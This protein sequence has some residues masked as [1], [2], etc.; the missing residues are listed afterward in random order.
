MEDLEALIRDH[1]FFAGLGPAHLA[2]L[3]GCA[4][5]VVFE[6]GAFIFREGEAAE[7]FYLMR[8][9]LVSLEIHG[10]ASG[11]IAIETRG[12][13]DVLGFSWLFPPHRLRFDARVL[14]PVRAVSFDGLCLRGKIEAD[15]ELGYELLQRFSQVLLDRLQAARLQ[16][17]DV[18]GNVGA[19]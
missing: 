13:G 15:H 3:A 14:E 1:P 4:S 9:G 6:P 10:P 11:P 18:Y 5:N 16:L 8:H 19:R 7:V 2:L 17:L 12:P